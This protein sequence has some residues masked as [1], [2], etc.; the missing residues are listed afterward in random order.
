MRHHQKR[1]DMQGKRRGELDTST[2]VGPDAVLFIGSRTA[3]VQETMW[4]PENSQK[5]LAQRAPWHPRGPRA[6][7][8]ALPVGS[9]CR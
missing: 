1:Q 4:R 2:W 5:A 3:S 7:D 9:E 8:P 6:K